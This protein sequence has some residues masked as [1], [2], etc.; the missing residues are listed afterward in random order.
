M[1]ANEH[2]LQ[3]STV[4]FRDMPWNVKTGQCIYTHDDIMRKQKCGDFNCTY[5]LFPVVVY[6]M[7]IGVGNERNV[8]VF[9]AHACFNWISYSSSNSGFPSDVFSSRTKS[10]GVG[11]RGINFLLNPHAFL[12]LLVLLAPSWSWWV[13]IFVVGLVSICTAYEEFALFVLIDLKCSRKRSR[14]SLSVCPT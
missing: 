10:Y 8:W 9:N 13:H 2:L 4:V 11:T 5:P 12:C 7:C 6:R 1:I 3:K 14:S